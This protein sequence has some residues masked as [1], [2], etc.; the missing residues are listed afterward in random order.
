MLSLEQQNRWR[1]RY[2]ALTPG[3]RPATELYAGHVRQLL[4]PTSHILDVGCGRGGLVEQLGHPLTHIVG[5]DPDWLSLH[6]HRLPLP[7]AVGLSQALPLPNASIDLV[8]ASWVLEHLAQPETDFRE[9]ARVLRPGGAL[10]FITP[11]RRHPLV[12]LN[13]WI[14]R[15]RWQSSLVARF[16]G[17]GQADTFAPFYRANTPD[18]LRR[19]A[20]RTHL[21]LVE[22]HAVADPTYLAFNAPLFHLGRWLE[23]RLPPERCLHLVGVARKG[24]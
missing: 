6:E 22:L 21:E 2:R 5:L 15:T 1:E 23:E 17:R 24:A 7:R 3:W 12:A 4:R 20:R 8:L 19:L 10:A 16:Y 11:N 9:I 18:D 13:G 14:G